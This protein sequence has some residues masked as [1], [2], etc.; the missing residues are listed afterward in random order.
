MDP[1]LFGV[2]VRSAPL[3]AEQQGR[4]VT[5]RTAY[6]LVKEGDET[7]EMSAIVKQLPE[8]KRIAECFSAQIGRAMGLPIPRP[9]VLRDAQGGLWFGAQQLNHPDLRRYTHPG[10]WAEQL[11]AWKPLPDACAFDGWIANEDRNLGNLLSDGR[12]K[13]W[14]I[15]HERALPSLRDPRHRCANQLLRLASAARQQSA[16]LQQINAACQQCAALHLHHPDSTGTSDMLEFLGIRASHL[17]PLL[18]SE[19][20]NNHELPGV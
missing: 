19:V 4:N 2:I 16:L 5:A 15:D 9:M 3:P 20:T 1:V 7:Q 18:R 12:G 13:F 17:W 6:V 8:R 10:Q 11:S 14:L